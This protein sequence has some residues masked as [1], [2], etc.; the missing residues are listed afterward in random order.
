MC[1]TLNH[2]SAIRQSGKIQ[3]SNAMGI[4]LIVT[5]VTVKFSVKT[6]GRLGIL[7][8]NATHGTK[9]T[10]KDP[11]IGGRTTVDNKEIKIH[12]DTCNLVA[13]TSQQSHSYL[14]CRKTAKSVLIYDAKLRPSGRESLNKR[15]GADKLGRLNSA[16][17]HPWVAFVSAQATMSNREALILLNITLQQR[18]ATTN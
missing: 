5:M 17:C 2:L 6:K 4:N 1:K 18:G 12:P 7:R 9:D 15:M 3:G 13:M 16:T 11:I 8:L 10:I 14:D